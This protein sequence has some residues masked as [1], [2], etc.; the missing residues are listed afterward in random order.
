MQLNG[1]LGGD[2]TQVLWTTR[3]GASS[4]ERRGAHAH[5]HPQCRGYRHRFRDADPGRGEQLH[6]A[7]DALTFATP[8]PYVNAGPDQTYCNQ[9]STFTLDGT[10]S[11]VTNVGQWTT[12]VR[13]RSPT[14]VRSRQ[15]IRPA[16]RTS[17]PGASTS[18]SVR[19]NNGKPAQVPG[20][21]R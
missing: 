9:V 8:A 17:R 14:R 15:P 18:R 16:R 1:V 11:G 2:A 7:S 19:L 3:H 20:P 5:L 12:T 21:T 10:I 4:P 6:N 13:A